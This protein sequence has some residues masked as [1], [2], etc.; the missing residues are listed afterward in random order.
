MK[1]LI[2]LTLTLLISCSD[3]EKKDSGSD[4]SSSNTPYAQF[5]DDLKDSNEAIKPYAVYQRL[6]QGAQM[7]DEGDGSYNSF[8]VYVPDQGSMVFEVDGQEFQLNRNVVT[9]IHDNGDFIQITISGSSYNVDQLEYKLKLVLK[10]DE[11]LKTHQYSG[12]F[13]DF[14]GGS[15]DSHSIS[16]EYRDDAIDLREW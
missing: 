13:N 6:F 16:S 7:L 11:N 15:N 2:A 8:D 14:T 4:S 3:G 9:M 12:L 10:V 5:M 1:T